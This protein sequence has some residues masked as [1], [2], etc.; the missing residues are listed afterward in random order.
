MSGT[1][2]GPVNTHAG[3][4]L[5]CRWS[6]LTRPPPHTPQDGSAA[7]DRL[8]IRRPSR[9]GSRPQGRSGERSCSPESCTHT[10]NCISSYSKTLLVHRTL[11][12]YERSAFLRQFEQRTRIRRNAACPRCVASDHSSAASASPAGRPPFNTRA[13]TARSQ[14]RTP[15]QPH[16]WRSLSLQRDPESLPIARTTP[17]PRMRWNGR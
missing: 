6:V 9:G 14:R 12:G 8:R 17:A 4:L 16:R 3:H 13:V 10:T 5:S 11:T 15:L 2:S 1:A 7:G